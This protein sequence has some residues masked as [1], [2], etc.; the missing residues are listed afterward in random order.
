[1]TD[2]RG[3]QDRGATVIQILPGGNVTWEEGPFNYTTYIGIGQI[4]FYSV[5]FLIQ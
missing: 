1:M 2:I 5:L 3:L 4:K